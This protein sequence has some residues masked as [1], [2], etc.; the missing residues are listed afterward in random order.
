MKAA[1]A[2][3]LASAIG[4]VVGLAPRRPRPVPDPVPASPAEG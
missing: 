2:V 1:A 4:A 3:A